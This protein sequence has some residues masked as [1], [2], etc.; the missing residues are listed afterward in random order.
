M[1]KEEKNYHVSDKKRSIFARYKRTFLFLTVSAG[2]LFLFFLFTLIVKDDHLNQ[3][4]FDMT[5][6][7]QDHVPLKFDRVFPYFSLLAKWQSMA[8]LLLIFLIWR[9]KIWSGLVIL[10]LFFSSHLIELFGKLFM[11]HPGP[12]FRFYRHNMSGFL[13]PENYVQAGSSYPSGH[14]FRVVFVGIL[15]GYVIWQH[16]RWSLVT[17]GILLSIIAGVVLLVSVSRV[18]LG[19]H[20][21]TDV[22]GGALFGVAMGAFG[23]VFL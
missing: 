1:E 20:W 22:I 13:F 15:L 11:H 6:R 12:P 7:F 2:F 23:L 21:T 18:S 5:V 4:D 17:K 16:K 3:F 8:V 9:K 14:S 10:F 19:E